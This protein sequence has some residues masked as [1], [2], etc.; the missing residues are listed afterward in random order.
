MPFIT[1]GLGQVITIYKG[2]HGFSPY[3]PF[4]IEKVLFTLFK[5]VN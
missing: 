1:P 3:V 2:S 4:T 5:T